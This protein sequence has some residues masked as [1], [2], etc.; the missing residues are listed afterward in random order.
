MTRHGKRIEVR[1]L[2][3]VPDEVR[4][5][6]LTVSEPAGDVD[7]IERVGET[8]L[9]HDKRRGKQAKREKR[10]R[11]QNEP[12]AH[13]AAPIPSGRWGRG[14]SP[15]PTTITEKTRTARSRT[16]NAT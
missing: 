7:V 14:D 15:P 4:G 13:R 16:A 9:D 12:A 10:Q 6:A 3:K 5:E 2:E 1:S 8:R 11:K